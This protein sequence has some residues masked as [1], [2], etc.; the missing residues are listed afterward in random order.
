[1]SVALCPFISQFL[2]LLYNTCNCSFQHS[3]YLF[4]LVVTGVRWLD[5]NFF[6]SCN[7]VSECYISPRYFCKDINF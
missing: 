3:S 1:L 4:Q 2:L 7:F 5:F 6:K